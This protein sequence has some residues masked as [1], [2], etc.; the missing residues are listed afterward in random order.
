MWAWLYNPFFKVLLSVIYV[1][2]CVSL[3]TSEILFAISLDGLLFAFSSLEPVVKNP[4]IH[5]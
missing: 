1:P 4:E 3:T 2:I 5:L